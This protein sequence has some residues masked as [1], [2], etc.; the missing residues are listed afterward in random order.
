MAVSEG[1]SPLSKGGIR[2]GLAPYKSATEL[3]VCSYLFVTVF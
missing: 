1:I 3:L 2:A